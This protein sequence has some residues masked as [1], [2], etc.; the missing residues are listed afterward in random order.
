MNRQLIISFFVSNSILFVKV[1]CFVILWQGARAQIM[2]QRKV[3]KLNRFKKNY[4]FFLQNDP[5]IFLF[6]L[7]EAQSNFKVGKNYSCN[8]VSMGCICYNFISLF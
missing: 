7:C 5:Q 6:F 8:Y 4:I 1:S 3:S 2:E